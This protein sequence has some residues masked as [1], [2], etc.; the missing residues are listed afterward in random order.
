MADSRKLTGPSFSHMPAVL[1]TY[2]RMPTVNHWSSS[3]NSPRSRAMRWKASG[4]LHAFSHTPTH[5]SR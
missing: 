2:P 1:C 3:Q 4:S 5:R